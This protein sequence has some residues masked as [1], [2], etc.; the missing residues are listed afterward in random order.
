MERIRQLLNINQ[1]GF[2]NNNNNNRKEI[3]GG[4]DF[5]KSK[6]GKER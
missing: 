5:I 4:E 2:N 3:K 1:K 6:K